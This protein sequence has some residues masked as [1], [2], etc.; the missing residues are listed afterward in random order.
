MIND[1]RK[2]FIRKA[3]ERLRT[4]Y[5]CNGVLA[6]DVAAI[7]QQY[8]TDA[9]IEILIKPLREMPKGEAIADTTERRL[10]IRSDVEGRLHDANVRARFTVAH[11]LGHFVLGHQG[12]SARSAFKDEMYRSAEE[13]NREK[14]AD[15]FAECFLMPADLIA[16]NADQFEIAQRFQVSEEAARIRL[17][18]LDRE[19]RKE[20]GQT[21]PLPDGVADFL[22]EAKARGLKINTKLPEEE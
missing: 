19:R 9:E 1:Q 4:K 7:L 16:E 3:A 2:A 13:N 6:P 11:E 22:R 10:L 18:N 21:R 12:M 14:E 5:S 20:T 17:E 15:Y 8:T